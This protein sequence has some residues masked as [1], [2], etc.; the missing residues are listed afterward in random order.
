MGGVSFPHIYSCTLTG[1]Q[2]P[3]PKYS[4]SQNLAIYW[5]EIWKKKIPDLQPRRYHTGTHTAVHVP[6]N[7]RVYT[8]MCTRPYVRGVHSTT[9]CRQASESGH[10]NIVLYHC[11]R[12]NYFPILSDLNS[13]TGFGE[14]SHPG[15]QIRS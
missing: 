11:A 13:E 6:Y 15:S 5:T 4:K 14:P 3:D 1:N 7:R 9:C 2:F 10:T 8:R 12:A